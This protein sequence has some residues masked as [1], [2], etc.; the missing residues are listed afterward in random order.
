MKKF[1]GRVGGFFKKLFSNKEAIKSAFDKTFE[2]SAKALPYLDTAA[3]IAAGVTPTK[4]DDIALAAIKS[5]YPRLF[6]GTIT[7]GE[8]LK[9][10]TLGVATTLLKRKYPEVSTTV[11]R[12]AV[13][14]AYAAKKEGETIA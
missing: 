11:A 1:F 7:T 14:T 6:D 2:L 8:E 13:Q 4:V 5:A 3:S 9:L 10:Y 12:L